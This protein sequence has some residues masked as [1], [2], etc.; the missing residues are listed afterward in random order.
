[1]LVNFGCEWERTRN[2][3]E[4]KMFYGDE[5]YLYP[6]PFYTSDYVVT[7][8]AKRK[9]LIPVNTRIVGGSDK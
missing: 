7:I 1:M 5:F 8:N 6:A 3:H 2:N 4:K 9:E